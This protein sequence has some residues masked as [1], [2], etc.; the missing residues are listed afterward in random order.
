[1]KIRVDGTEYECE[2]V[3]DGKDFND[4][5]V[6]TLVFEGGK[7]WPVDEKRVTQQKGTE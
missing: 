6:K 2:T 4:K 7:T 3:L 1:M 5:P